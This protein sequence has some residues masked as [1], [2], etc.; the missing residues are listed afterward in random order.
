M[1]ER[2]IYPHSLSSLSPSLSLSLSLS[3]SHTLSLNPFL[4][5]AS[6]HW[7]DDISSEKKPSLAS[8]R[9]KMDWSQILQ[10]TP[11]ALSPQPYY[12]HRWP[13]GRIRRTSRPRCD[14]WWDNTSAL[15]SLSPSLTPINAHV[16]THTHTHIHIHT[17]SLSFSW[18]HSQ[19][20][21]HSPSHAS[22]SLSISIYLVIAT[23]QL[24]S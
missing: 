21:S 22:S 9:R 8:I 2:I 4:G 15:L 24:T 12:Q 20:L 16:Y 10:L 6:R 5:Q 19:F 14:R 13:D 11:P 1:S 7:A 18:T 17:L 23:S 3:N